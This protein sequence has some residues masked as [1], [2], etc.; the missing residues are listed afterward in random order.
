MQL[1]SRSLLYLRIFTLFL[2]CSI[3]IDSH[4]LVLSLNRYQQV[5][6]MPFGFYPEL[7]QWNRRLSSSFVKITGLDTYYIRMVS[8]V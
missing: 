3:Y 1:T 8:I 2:F 7:L 6:Q 4:N 5:F